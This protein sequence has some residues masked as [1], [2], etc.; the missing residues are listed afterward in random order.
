ML[1][2]SHLLVLEYYVYDNIIKQSFFV[3]NV[4]C[5]GKNLTSV[6]GFHHVSEAW[7]QNFGRI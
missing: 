7:K 4:V 2:T 3:T 1:L 5:V 6:T